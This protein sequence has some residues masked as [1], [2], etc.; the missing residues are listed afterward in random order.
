[1]PG[2]A[3]AH[4]RKSKMKIKMRKRTKRKSTITSRIYFAELLL[5][6]SQLEFLLVRVMSI[7]TAR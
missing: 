2:L 6:C 3:H 1:M 4:E 5:S 7:Q